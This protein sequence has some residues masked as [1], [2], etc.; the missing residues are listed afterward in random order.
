MAGSFY[1]KREEGL[2]MGVAMAVASIASSAYSYYS[3]DQM[4]KAQM[5]Q[6]K[7]QNEAVHR[8]M[9]EQYSEMSKAERSEIQANLEDSQEVQAEYL[10]RKANIS[11]L[12][13]TTGTSGLSINQLLA[14]NRGEQG[15]NFDTL[16]KNR[17][18]MLDNFRNQASSIRA[19]GINQTDTRVLQRPSLLAA[20]LEM[21]AAGIQGYSAGSKIGEQ[22]AKSNPSGG[23][24]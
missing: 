3:Q 9:I 22:L 8:N 16:L 23:T 18:V 5:R 6:Q 12:S 10:R 24:K 21:G 1:A 17:T 20:G 13:N 7:L 14:A 4:T 2:D 19:G 11:L 15:K